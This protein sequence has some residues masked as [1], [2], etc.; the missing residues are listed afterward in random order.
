MYVL[1]Q[2]IGWYDT[3]I[4]LALVYQVHSLPFA[5]WLIRSFFKEVPA[6]LDDASRIDGCEPPGHIAKRLYSAGRAGHSRHRDPHRHL[7]LERID[8]R[9]VPLFQ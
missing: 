6:E 5:V 9:L 7:D 8:H 1:Y 4:G 3:H 2:R